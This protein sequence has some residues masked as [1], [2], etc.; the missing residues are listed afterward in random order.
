MRTAV[1]DIAKIRVF[2]KNR[3][4]CKAIIPAHAETIG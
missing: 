3:F 1:S 2:H 4:L